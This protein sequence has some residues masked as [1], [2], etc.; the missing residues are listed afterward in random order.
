MRDVQLDLES[1]VSTDA[2]TRV[3]GCEYA[4][5]SASKPMSTLYV[6]AVQV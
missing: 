3:C 2:D 4:D 6:I 1:C 5:C